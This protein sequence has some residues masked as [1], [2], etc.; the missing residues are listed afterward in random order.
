MSLSTICTRQV[1]TAEL[2]ESV[3]QVAERVRQRTVGCLI[4]VD[5]SGKPIGIVTDR[6]LV[7]RVLAAGRDPHATLVAD[8]M[9]RHPDVIL[10]MLN[11]QAA[12]SLMRRGRFRRLPVVDSNGSLVGLLTLDD[13][14]R[15]LTEQFRHISA[16]LQS[17]SPQAAAD[18]VGSP[19]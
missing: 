19:S 5:K 7:M 4:V 15:S 14:L 16:I 6:D 2:Q 13:V 18:V 8:V 17:E 1:D 11:V 9:T 3:W 10:E 12:V